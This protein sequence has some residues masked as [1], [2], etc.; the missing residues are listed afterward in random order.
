V[1]QPLPRP[2]DDLAVLELQ[3][4]TAFWAGQMAQAGDLLQQLL[5]RKGH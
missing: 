4:R 1:I 5:E 2:H 3:A